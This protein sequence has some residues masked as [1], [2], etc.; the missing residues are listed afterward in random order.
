MVRT[1]GPAVSER[2]R[3]SAL[4]TYIVDGR[5]LA[6][7]HTYL[8]TDKETGNTT[9]YDLTP[10][11]RYGDTA[12]ECAWW[13]IAAHSAFTYFLGSTGREPDPPEESVEICMYLAVNDDRTLGNLVWEYRGV[14]P[15]ELVDM[16][17]WARARG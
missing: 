17:D 5:S 6:E 1:V 3:R 14:L 9:R 16:L 12:D 7:W 10:G 2:P 8:T 13:A 4:E 11:S 15:P